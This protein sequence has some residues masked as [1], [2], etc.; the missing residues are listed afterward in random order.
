MAAL[1]EIALRREF[2]MKD[3]GPL[4]Y[5]LGI[6]IQRSDS[7]LFLSQQKY[8][9][10]ILARAK[11]ENCNP[12]LT[13]VDTSSKQSAT[14]G[15]PIDDPTFFCSLAGALQYLTF[16]RPDI[17]PTNRYVFSCT[18]HVPLISQLSS[19]YHAI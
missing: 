3:L 18:I 8:I 7:G 15:A 2:D 10:E 9:H 11:M 14:T 13:P 4:H 12:C 5:F 17:S 19:V 6:S 16:T 1:T